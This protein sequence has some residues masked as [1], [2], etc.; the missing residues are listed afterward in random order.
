MKP[1]FYVLWLPFLMA[2]ALWLSSQSKDVKPT[3]TDQQKLEIRSAQ[4]QLYQAKEVLE[5]TP[6]FK[7]FQNAQNHLNETALRIQRESKVDPK[8]W[9]LGQDLEYVAVPQPAP[10]KK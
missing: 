7:A 4:V 9:T 8:Q 3:L 10:E 5:S 2:S 6:Q 1:I